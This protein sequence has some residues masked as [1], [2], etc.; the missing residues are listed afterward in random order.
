S[1]S[2]FGPGR[3]KCLLSPFSHLLRS[4]PA[5]CF[6]RCMMCIVTQP[7][8][9][10]RKRCLSSRQLTSTSAFSAKSCPYT[11]SCACEP[12]FDCPQYRPC[13]V[14]ISCFCASAIRQLCM[15]RL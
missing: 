15:D 10:K 2:A 14:S 3:S 12:I 9:N 5:R 11:F 1:L 13:N 8:S 4:H 7:R 6:P